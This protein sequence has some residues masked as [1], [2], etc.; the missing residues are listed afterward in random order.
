M[1]NILNGKHKEAYWKNPENVYREIFANLSAI[2]VLDYESR[3]EC[4]N[5]LKEV[6]EA[7][8]ELIA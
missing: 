6:Y 1:N 8:K 7:Y 2:D 3:T 4:K 5:I